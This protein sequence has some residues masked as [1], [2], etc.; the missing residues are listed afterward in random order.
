A[1]L[2][3]ILVDI[4][5]HR[6]TALEPPEPALLQPGPAL[7]LLLPALAFDRQHVLGQRALDVLRIHTGKVDLDAQAV[8]LFRD[9]DLGRDRCPFQTLGRLW[10]EA[11]AQESVEDLV[12]LSPDLLERVEGISRCGHESCL[13]AAGFPSWIRT[14]AR[15]TRS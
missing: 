6:D 3:S 4:V 1:G 10:E 8:V 11:L 9:V 2:E 13:L 14:H 5:R 15:C 12:E 7:D